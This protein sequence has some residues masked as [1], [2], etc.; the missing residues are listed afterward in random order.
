MKL[1]FKNFDWG[2]FLATILLLSFGLLVIYSTSPEAAKEQLIF[3]VLGLSAYLFVLSFDYNILKAFAGVLYLFSLLLLLFTYFWGAVFHGAA[4]W[5]ALGGVTFQPSEI[6]KFIII[7]ALGAFFSS[8]FWDKFS[9]RSFGLSLF[10]VL[11]PVAFVYLQP[12]L[13]TALILLAIWL[14]IAVIAGVRPLFLLLL[15]GIFSLSSIPLFFSLKD[16][17]QQRILTFFN[18]SRD[19]LGSG[20]HVGQSLIAV[21]SGQLFG[22][23]FGRGTQ[24]HLKFLPAYH[25]DF[26]FA[27]L[28]E[29]WGFIGSFALLVLISFFLWRLLKVSISATDDFGLLV[30]VGVFSMIFFQTAVS[31]G[32]N[33][34][35]MPVTGIPLP[36]ISSGGSSLITTLVALGLAQSVAMRRKI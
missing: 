31:I 16:Y 30:A 29:E 15:L 5:F 28:A 18:P 13:G 26:I 27:A 21:G 2:L 10:A 4:R 35:L 20:Y 11:L 25:T 19:P 9:L 34:G 33:L 1:T 14:G 6:S 7:L 3:A 24:S 17:Q 36:L 12:D 32:M 23:G 8:R 22:R